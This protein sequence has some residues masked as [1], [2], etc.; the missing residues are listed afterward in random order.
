[1]K[2]SL[3][4]GSRR[5]VIHVVVAADKFGAL[6]HPNNRR[7]ADARADLLQCLHH[8]LASVAE[9]S[10]QR[11]REPRECINNGQDPNLS[12]IGQL[13][14]NKIHGPGFFVV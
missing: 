1:M 4:T 8:I 5:W 14:M 9:S 7:I 6:I 11:W 3:V 10:I 12:A 2:R 13:V